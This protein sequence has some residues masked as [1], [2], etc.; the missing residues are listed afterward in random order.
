MA[1]GRPPRRPAAVGRVQ[2]HPQRGLRS[3]AYA[4]ALPCEDVRLP[5]DPATAA[6]VSTGI[7]AMAAD[8]AVTF[9]NGVRS[10][11]Y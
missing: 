8:E 10:R 3:A 7:V 9:M 6:G 1:R 11:G 5:A 4:G 2:R